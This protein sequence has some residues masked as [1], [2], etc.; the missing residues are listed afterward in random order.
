MK[1][2]NQKF[3]R[4]T[5]LALLAAVALGAAGQAH[6]QA[7]YPNAEA[8]ADALVTSISTGDDDLLK[9]VLGADYRRYVPADSVSRDDI[10]AFLAAWSKHHEVVTTGP[11]S[12]AFIVGQ[13][14]WPFPAPLVKDARGWHFD[15]RE[16]AREMQRRRIDRNEIA[17]ID[18]LQVLC[19]A[20]QAYRSSVGQGRP[21]QRIVS[22]EGRHDGLYWDAGTPAP[23]PSP[24]S[25]DALVM[26]ADVPVD[27]AL[28]GYRYALLPSADDSG[29][30]FAAWPAAYGHSGQHS[31]VIGPDRKVRE[32]DFGRQSGKAGFR[33]AT[34]D[35]G[36]Q[37]SEAMP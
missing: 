22:S 6:A 7:A 24:L 34:G 4:A 18:T 5:A 33:G 37:W 12:A 32:R 21:A 20:Q 16:G 36:A 19:Q 23:G 1:H 27:A 29:C 13:H 9:R 11:K 8:A 31:F 25:D 26:G 15:V 30:A 10:Y 17:A 35:L 3:M 2:G 14:G 28:H